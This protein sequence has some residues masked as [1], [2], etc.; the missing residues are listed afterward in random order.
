[1]PKA[2]ARLVMS[3]IGMCCLDGVDSAQWLCSQTNTAGTFQSW[4]RLSA[5][6]KVPMFV[7]P[8]PKNATATLGLA[9][10]T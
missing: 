5:S 8:S 3:S 2:S 9:A 10:G 6:W 1:M 7:A 4:A